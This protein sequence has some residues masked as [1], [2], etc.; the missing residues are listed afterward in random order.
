MT[1]A[2]TATRNAPTATAIEMEPAERRSVA[3]ETA[4]EAP[5]SGDSATLPGEMTVG[6]GPAVRSDRDQWP[7]LCR[8]PAA[9]DIDAGEPAWSATASRRVTCAL[10]ETD[11]GQKPRDDR[12]GVPHLARIELVA[13]P[14]R[15][16]DGW[17]E[18]EDLRDERRGVGD[19]DGT[20]NG[21]GEV[22]DDPVAPPS[23]L[24]AEDAEPSCE[25]D[26]HRALPDHTSVPGLAASR[27][28]GHLDHGG[29]LADAG[30]EGRVIE[31][32]AWPPLHQRSERLVGPAADSNDR[33]TRSEGYPVQ[34]EAGSWAC[35]HHGTLAGRSHLLEGLQVRSNG[36]HRPCRYG[37][38]RSTL[39]S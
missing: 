1:T 35:V 28:W 37:T 19:V 7:F 39:R 32:P 3:G 12:I 4:T 25:G 36:D 17:D 18:V 34:V 14:H 29:A 13:S 11:L 8:P 16:R 22:R 31:V 30:D 38:N 20:G 9:R 10:S 15:S 27:D 2:S 24:V 6:A 26:A 21:V 23:N 33:G 5:R